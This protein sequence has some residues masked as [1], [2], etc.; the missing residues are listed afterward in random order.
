MVTRA[1]LQ[2]EGTVPLVV[3]YVDPKDPSV[4]IKTKQKQN[5]IKKA[6]QIWLEQGPTQKRGR[7]TETE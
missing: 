3:S 1:W 5:K 6:N 2:L 4:W 7:N